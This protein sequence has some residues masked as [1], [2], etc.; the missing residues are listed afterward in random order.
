MVDVKAG[1]AGRRGLRRDDVG[2]D[3]GPRRA[4][5]RVG[6]FGRGDALLG[7]HHRRVS[8]RRR[9][10]HGARRHER[11]RRRRRPSARRRRRSRRNTSSP[12]SPTRRWS[13]STAVL[14]KAD[15]GTI[16]VYSGIAVPDRSTR[17]AVAGDA[18]PRPGAGA[19]P[20]AARRRRLRPPGAGRL[21]LRQ[22]SRGGV[23]GARR[24][25]VRSST[26]GC[27]RTTFAAAIY[28]PIYVHRLKGAIGADGAISAWEQVIVG[29]SIIAGTP[30]EAMMKDGIDPTSVEGASDLPY[31]IAEPA[32]LAAHHEDRRAG[33][34]VAL[35]RPHPHR[36]HHRDFHRRAAGGGRQGSGRGPARA[37]RREPAPHAACSSGS[38][39][40]PIGAAR[41]RRAARAASRCTR[42]S[43]PM[44]PRS[45]RFP[46]RD[47]LPRVHKVWCAVDC[48]VPI[49][50]NIIR[51]QMEGGIG[52][53]LGAVL[54]G[55]ISLGEG[56]HVS[57]VEFPRLPLA[58]HQRDAGGRGG[59]H[60]IDRETPTGVG[61]PGVPPIGPAVANA[62]R[63]L[64]GQP[65]RRLPFRRRPRPGASRDPA[66]VVAGARRWRVLRA[67][68]AAVHAPAH[69]R[70]QSS[71][72]RLR[73]RGH[74]RR[75]RALGRALRG[76]RK[77]HP[78]S[79]LRE[80]PSGRR[81]CRC[82]A[83][84]CARTSR[85]CCS[86]RSRF[87]HGR[88]DLQHL[89]RHGER[90]RRRARRTTSRAFP[91]IRTGISR[92]SR[93][94]G[95]GSR[96][97]KSA[98][99]SRIR[100]GTAARIIAAIVEHMAE[101]DLVGWGWDPGEGR[102]PVPGTQEE[103]GALFHAWAESGAVCPP[104]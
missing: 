38:P 76:G 93:W 52:F 83:W 32:R 95:R 19:P 64:T 61:E 55:E 92:R 7:D 68:L 26:S 47:G 28:R 73:L 88:H 103:F 104:A 33:A 49:N 60:P 6:H 9:S 85:R 15:D 25:R 37:A 30:F 4:E 70:R 23:Q 2:G 101:D 14:V 5:G 35:G 1:P 11:G 45:P 51:A 8:A 71:A 87:R 72:A 90:R 22:R 96:S 42:A 102:E 21:A 27:A 78:A 3:Q 53:G 29:Q 67:A 84:R 74:R 59:D 41:F 16:D 48:G 94:R 99:R 18:R 54:F 63:R 13:R 40:W 56:G 10:A 82:R 24:R 44:S 65:V 69:R 75:K 57:A 46:T 17:Q 98:S 77:G 34:L 58:P 100:R 12:T 62:W 91:A 50:P 43:T 31:A 89:P 80:L 81:P 97:A 39:R 86:R 36:L 66:A 79:A 20:H